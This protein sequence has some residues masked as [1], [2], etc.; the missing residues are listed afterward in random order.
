M[1]ERKSGCVCVCASMGARERCAQ[2]ERDG[3]KEWLCVRERLDVC[4]RE[5]ER[6]R[7]KDTEQARE[8]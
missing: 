7:V 6:K 4:V 2:R 1:C 8:R 5:R 3:E